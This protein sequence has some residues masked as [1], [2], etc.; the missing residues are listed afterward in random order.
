[1]NFLDRR[2]KRDITPAMREAVLEDLPEL[3]EIGHEELRHKCIDVWCLALSETGFLRV[4]DV[5]GESNPGQFALRSGDQATHL[6][7]VTRIALSIAREF[8]A[9]DPRVVIDMDL[10]IAGGLTHDVGKPWEFDPENR[11]RWTED[12]SAS[13]LPSLRHSVYGAH[14]CIAVGLPEAIAHMALAHSHEGEGVIRSLE[15]LIVQRADHL[16]WAIAGG[17]GLLE[18][19]GDAILAGRRIAPRPLRG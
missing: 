18:P 10:V 11:R 4:R 3:A 14:L 1:M 8:A 16:W 12:P 9:M 6:R 15:C 17:C 2:P 5:P 7:G 13:G 19:G